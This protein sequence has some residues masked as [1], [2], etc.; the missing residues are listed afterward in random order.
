MCK[1]VA[2]VSGVAGRF[3]F[4]ASFF[5]KYFLILFVYIFSFLEF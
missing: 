4:W 2:G 1:V 3:P 5:S